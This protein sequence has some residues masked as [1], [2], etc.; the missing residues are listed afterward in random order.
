MGTGSTRE[1][2]FGYGSSQLTPRNARPVDP[3]ASA[4]FNM[5]ERK[6]PTFVKFTEGEVVEGIL[7]NVEQVEVG[8]PRK[9]AMR[10]TVEDMDSHDLSSFLGCYQIDTKL[11]VTDIGHVI[12]V[13]F[14]G[15]DNSVTRNGRAMKKFQVSVSEKRV[16]PK[17]AD[18]TFISD[19][20][21]G[22]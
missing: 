22:F 9:K 7:V 6:E 18:G 2:N 21:I 14:E 19:D 15:D 10:Y 16:N 3:A 13:R 20:D 5:R 1:P 12:H 8:E 17:L 11:R 4:S